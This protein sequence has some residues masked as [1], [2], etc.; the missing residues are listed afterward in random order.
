MCGRYQ[1]T[2]EQSAEIRQMIREIQDRLGAP[3]AKAIP[4]GE[5]RPGDRV[6]ALLAAEDGP[7]P[8]LLTWGFRT[9]RSLLINARAETVLEKPAFAESARHRHCAIPSTGF[10]EW[11]GDKRKFFFSMPDA[12][13]LYM[14]GI[15]DV[16][17]GVP[18]FT[19]LTTA[20]NESMRG[21]HDRMPLVLERGQVEPWLYDLKAT[22]YYLTMTPPLLDRQLLDA[23]IGLW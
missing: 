5:I 1:F 11:D 9:T 22:E 8:E 23:Q 16:R 18:C 17:D 14:A 13:E 21:I 19:I 20:A 6:P 7:T 4:Q 2:A 12:H 15:F 10:Y 3:T